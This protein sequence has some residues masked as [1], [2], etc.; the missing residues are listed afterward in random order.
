[1]K[2][3]DIAHNPHNWRGHPDA[4]RASFR[5][6]VSEVGWAGMPLVYHSERVGGLTYVDGHMRKEELPDFEADVAITDL[7]DEEADLILATYDPISAQA[8]ANREKLGALL[9]NVQSGEA[10]VQALLAG[11]AEREGIFFGGNEPP[12]DPGPQIDRASELQEKWGV[13][14]GDL[15]VIPSKTASG[16]HRVVCGDCTDGAVEKTTLC[17]TDPPYGINASSMT[18]GS[19][20]SSRPKESR[21]SHGQIW[22]GNRPDISW[23]LKTAQWC[24]IW[25]GNYFSDILPVTNDWLCW[26]KKNDGLSF[27]EF[28][29]AWTNYG[30][31][32]RHIAHHWGAETK[33]HITQ[34]PLVV[35]E[36]AIESCPNEDGLVFDPF[37][38]SGTTLV[39]CERLARLGRGVEIEPKYVAVTLER[40]AGM[41]LEPRHVDRI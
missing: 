14:T 36:W 34:K 17:H 23:L 8:E 4:Q 10:G 39:A 9:Q 12:E 41:G 30:K 3:G 2:L 5:G 7:N 40:L 35:V 31:Q 32:S 22:D 26:H 25:G 6:V 15:W 13:E 38:G 19:G 16:E 21:L 29:L 18:M 28:E 33:D 1:M 20:Q 27:S 11:L 37:L 24:C